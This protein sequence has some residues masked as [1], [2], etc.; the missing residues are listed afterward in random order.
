MW[1]RKPRP[2]LET[3]AVPNDIHEAVE[4]R[5][6]N[7]AELV[8]LRKKAPLIERL[9]GVQIERLGKNHYLETL[10]QHVEGVT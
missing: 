4:L 7:R 5:A 10:Y 1:R 8:D 2:T 9:T 6:E 3:P